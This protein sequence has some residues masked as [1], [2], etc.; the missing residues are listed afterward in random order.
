MDKSVAKR[1]KSNKKGTGLIVF[2][3]KKLWFVFK[4]GREN[5]ITAGKVKCNN[6]ESAIDTLNCV[7]KDLNMALISSGKLMSKQR[8]E[9]TGSLTSVQTV[10]I[11]DM[12]HRNFQEMKIKMKFPMLTVRFLILMIDHLEIF[13]NCLTENGVRMMKFV[14]TINWKNLFKI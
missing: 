6:I 2:L 4:S 3:S 10:P 12:I 5:D 8:K 13:F 7:V 9:S 11:L 1:Y 14:I